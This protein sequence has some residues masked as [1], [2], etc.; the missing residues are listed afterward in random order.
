M[1]QL[2]PAL[3]LGDLYLM[4]CTSGI[5][6]VHRASLFPMG[7]VLRTAAHGRCSL[8][9][10]QRWLL[11]IFS[12][13]LA[14]HSLQPGPAHS[15]DV[16]RSVLVACAGTRLSSCAFPPWHRDNPALG[17]ACLVLARYSNAR[18]RKQFVGCF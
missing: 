13:V 10:V 9:P 12:C 16:R 7:H 6:C 15:R 14:A 4:L 3:A 17:I 8:W 11:P 2:C 1:I 18:K 5:L